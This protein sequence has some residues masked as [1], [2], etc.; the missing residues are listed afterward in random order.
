MRRLSDRGG[1]SLSPREAAFLATLST[2]PA[3][4]PGG[5]RH[6]VVTISRVPATL[7]GRSRRESIAAYPSAAPPRILTSRRESFAGGPP[8]TE[9]RG[10]IH[11]LQLDIMDD[12]VTA[13]KTKVRSRKNEQ[14]DEPIIV[15]PSSSYFAPAMASAS[16]RRCSDLL[17]GPLPTIP[18]DS[19][20]TSTNSSLLSSLAS[21]ATEIDR[22]HESTPLTTPRSALSERK[23][24]QLREARSNSF[25]ATVLKDEGTK[26]GNN[27]STGWFTK[28]HQPM[29]SKVS[30]TSSVTI[31]ANKDEAKKLWDSQN[32]T[33][34][35]P[36]IP[37]RKLD[38]SKGAIPKNSSGW[39][40]KEG[41]DDTSG[42][43]GDSS[44]C[45]TL[46]DLFVK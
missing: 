27:H 39:Y 14:E 33:K 20:A 5:R 46:K 40:A 9:H 4:S 29:T 30:P 13:R 37:P 31:P 24:N 44:L 19:C 6:S 17:I 28:R 18:A 41:D 21:S 26:Q 25:D 16:A 7:F 34:T 12:I 11:N 23:R 45:S 38:T 2:A 8:S 32:K 1:E 10:S 42:A 35:P 15:A 22:L 36:E 3:P 43:C